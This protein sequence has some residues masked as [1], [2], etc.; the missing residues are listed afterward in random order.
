MEKDKQISTENQSLGYVGLSRASEN[1]FVNEGW[2][3][4]EEML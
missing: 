2:V 4:F 1:L 3:S